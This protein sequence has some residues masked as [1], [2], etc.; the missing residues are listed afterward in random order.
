MGTSEHREILEGNKDP[1]GDPLI[2]LV[3]I[4]D[5]SHLTS[6]DFALFCFL[7]LAPFFK[8]LILFFRSSSDV[9][10][11]CCTEK[12]KKPSKKEIC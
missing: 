8:L 5:Y 4:K 2:S 10:Y 12:K 1:L 3:Q 7:R 6:G 9:A 11:V